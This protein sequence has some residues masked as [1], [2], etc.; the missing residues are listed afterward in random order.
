LIFES[1]NYYDTFSQAQIS[2]PSRLNFE[3]DGAM[4]REPIWNYVMN[5]CHT[6]AARDCNAAFSEIFQETV[7]L[8]RLYSL[9]SS[10]I[11]MNYVTLVVLILEVLSGGSK[12][13]I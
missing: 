6:F 1:C 10:H 13:P 4:A 9:Q 8:K 7:F 11:I 2:V 5:L 12:S 3:L